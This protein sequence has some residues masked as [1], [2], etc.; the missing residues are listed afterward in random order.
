MEHYILPI[1][2][3]SGLNRGVQLVMGGLVIGINLVIY[4]IIIR[5]RRRRMT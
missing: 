4:G 3:P 1:L 2:Y 5:R